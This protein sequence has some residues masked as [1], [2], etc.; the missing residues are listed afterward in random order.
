MA[1]EFI[2]FDFG[3]VLCYFDHRRAAR[4]MA[5][6]SGA[7]EQQIW[8]LVFGPNGIEWQ[9]EAGALDE[10]GFH[11]AFCRGT[12]TSPAIDALLRANAEIFWLN[13][14]ILPLVAAL[15][16]A[17]YP[18]GVLS[19]TC[20]S[21]WKAVVDGRYAILPGAFREIV[22]SCEVCALKPDP[23]IYRQAI[24]R[25][26]VPAERIF[27]MDDIAGHIEGAKR[28]GIDGVQYTTTE[29]LVDELRQRGVRCNF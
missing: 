6:V 8:D 18:L 13:A 19:N 22:L 2:Y 14:S 26:G 21:H 28:A 23:K 3:N 16:D 10:R 5:E 25:A 15:E 1:T 27:Y 11:E 4:Q 24:E 17:G 12:G 7:A 20:W 29:V 9:Y